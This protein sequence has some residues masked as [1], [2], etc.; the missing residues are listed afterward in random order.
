MQRGGVEKSKHRNPWASDPENPVTPKVTEQPSNTINNARGATTPHKDCKYQ[1][2]KTP[3][4]KHRRDAISRSL[5]NRQIA[6]TTAPAAALSVVP[7]RRPLHGRPHRSP[8]P[9]C[10]QNNRSCATLYRGPLHPSTPPAATSGMPHHVERTSSSTA[11]H[12]KPLH[13]APGC[14]IR[15]TP[16]AKTLSTS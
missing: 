5:G 13:S 1:K 3:F 14:G 4:S 11:K 15:D 7:H 12:A 9:D 2:H 6:K 10:P 8:I 16:T